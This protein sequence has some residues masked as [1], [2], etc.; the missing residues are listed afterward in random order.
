VMGEVVKKLEQQ[1]LRDSVRVFI[2]GAPT[3]AV[4]AQEIGADAYCK[5]GFDAIDILKTWQ[6][7][8]KPGRF[9]NSRPGVTAT[10]DI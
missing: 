8:Q 6:R 4:F 7:K 9:M 3:S 2:G 10:E 5:D 1:G